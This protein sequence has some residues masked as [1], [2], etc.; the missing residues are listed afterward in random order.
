MIDART[1][2][3][4]SKAP[5]L[6]TKALA[7]TRSQKELAERLGVTPKY[8]QFLKSGRSTNMSYLVQVGLELLIEQNSSS[9]CGDK[10]NE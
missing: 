4:P 10:P 6:I 1:H 8:L 2:H 3:D 9:R 7:V 5:E